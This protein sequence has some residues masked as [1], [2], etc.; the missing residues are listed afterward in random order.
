MEIQVLGGLSVQLST[1]TL[2]LGTPKQQA[3]FA[4]L[5]VQPGQLVTVDE[6]VD[7]LWERLPTA[8]SRR[9]CSHLCRQ[10]AP[11][12]RGLPVGPSG[13]SCGSGTA[14]DSTYRRS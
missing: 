14:I 11:G 1:R 3:I 12:F 2:R 8:I 4:M 10:S 7:E 6:L 5:A 13:S 9:E